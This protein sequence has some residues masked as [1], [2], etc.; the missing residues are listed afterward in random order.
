MTVENTGTTERGTAILSKVDLESRRIKRLPSG[1][2]IA[3]YFDNICLVVKGTLITQQFSVINILALHAPYASL[4]KEAK[5]VVETSSNF[6]GRHLVLPIL[7]AAVMFSTIYCPST[8]PYASLKKEAKGGIET[9]SKFCQ[10]P[11]CFTYS[12]GGR[13][14]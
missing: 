9:S 14:L 3:D 6:V 11:S 2:G 13:A 1:R 10:P 4:K 5:D 12:Y 8:P 7:T